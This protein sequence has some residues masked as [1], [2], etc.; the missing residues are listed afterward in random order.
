MN[1]LSIVEPNKN[2]AMAVGMVPQN[3]ED[4]NRLLNAMNQPDGRLGDKIN[5]PLNVVNFFVQNVEVK[6]R[7]R[8]A[9]D[10]PETVMLPRVVVITDD[11]ASYGCASKGVYNALEKICAVYG[12]PDK[13]TAPMTCVLKHVPT[14]QGSMYSLNIVS[15]NGNKANF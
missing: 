2:G 8:K 4:V 6:N 10:D 7:N 13:W 12:M 15:S 11:G 5:Q 14:Q 1:M 9:D 3:E